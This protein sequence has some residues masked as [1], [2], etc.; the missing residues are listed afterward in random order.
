M[1]LAP[2]LFALLFIGLIVG[3]PFICI[4]LF[5][6]NDFDF[7]IYGL[8][9]NFA[10][11]ACLIVSY[12]LWFLMVNS[13]MHSLGYSDYIIEFSY[14]FSE[15][16]VETNQEFKIEYFYF[17]MYLILDLGISPL[18][19]FCLKKFIV[20]KISSK[21]QILMFI[22]G[23]SFC[24]VVPFFFNFLASINAIGKSEAFEADNISYA[25]LIFKF[26]FFTFS[27]LLQISGIIILIFLWLKNNYKLMLFIAIGAFFGPFL[28]LIIGIAA[29]SA[30]MTDILIPILYWAPLGAGLFFYLKSD[31]EGK[32]ST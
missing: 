30:F 22:S 29:R 2:F 21:K 9:C 19:F 8:L 23:F 16:F 17:L 4:F 11:A 27:Y 5:K 13:R 32:I 20:D 25:G 31:E 6:L 15:W 26:E 10:C 18:L 24:F 28:F 7:L 14:T 12:I 1:H 3:F